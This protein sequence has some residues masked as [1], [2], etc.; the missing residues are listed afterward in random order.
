[1]EAFFSQFFQPYPTHQDYYPNNNNNNNNN[2]NG[3][4]PDRREN[5]PPASA[6]LVAGLPLV[7]VTADDLLEETNKEC[8]VCLVEQDLGSVACK[9]P[10]GHLFHK[11]CVTMWLEKKC[12]CPVCRYELETDDHHYE[13]QRKQRMKHRKLRMRMDELKAKPISQLR[14]LAGELQVSLQGC[15]D[16]SEVIHALLASGRIDILEGL[17]PMEM[18]MSDFLNKSVSELRHLLLSFGLTV[19]GALEK[20]D[21][22]TAL[23]QSG[24]ILFIETEEVE[25]EEVGE[26][27]GDNRVEKEMEK[28]VD[29]QE[30]KGQEVTEKGEEE[31]E[32]GG[33]GRGKERE[34]TESSSS[35][36]KASSPS[37]A[38]AEDRWEEIKTQ[39]LSSLRQLAASLGVSL[40]GCLDRQ[41]VL[42]RLRSCPRLL[43]SS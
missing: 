21:F 9:L 40:A 29:V 34:Q 16:K 11:P 35:E 26:K 41:D 42:D 28:E 38:E 8:V 24:R 22:R 32:E 19:E 37:A 25:V 39:P 20:D 1:M 17:P 14:R 7:K 36:N 13:S 30:S 2:N 10:C 6:R 27:A 12:T 33:G 5:T 3:N 43:H 18:T 15:L 31:E 23:M 4:N